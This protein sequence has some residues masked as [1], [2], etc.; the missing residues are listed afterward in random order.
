V[1]DITAK[2]PI[3]N[4]FVAVDIH[5]IFHIKCIVNHTIR[6]K[7][8]VNN[9]EPLKVSTTVTVIFINHDTTV[10][11]GQGLHIIEDS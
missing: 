6:L 3:A 7:T 5:T 2:L 10:P 11:V 9:R 8:K 1:S 4:R